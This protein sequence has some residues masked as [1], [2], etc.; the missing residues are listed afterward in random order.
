MLRSPFFLL[1]VLALGIVLGIGIGCRNCFGRKQLWL[2]LVASIPAL[3][4]LLLAANFAARAWASRPYHVYR[5]SFDLEPTA[6]VNITNS[7]WVESG[8]SCSRYL[9]FYANQPTI[10]RIIAA[11]RVRPD[12]STLS[13]GKANDPGWW[14]PSR[15]P[16]TKVYTYEMYFRTERDESGSQDEILVY[17]PSTREAYYRYIGTE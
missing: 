12:R 2:V 10:D 3:L 6:D 11:G 16:K 7:L 4:L 17:N 8:G 15:G 13:F 14:K 9:R 1:L 5:C